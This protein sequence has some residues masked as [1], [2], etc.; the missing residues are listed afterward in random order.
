[1]KTRRD[2][3]KAGFALGA[4]FSLSDLS[5]LYAADAA[6]APAPGGSR[7][8]LVA[9]RDGDRVAMLDKALAELGGIGA[10]VKPGQTVL[11]KPNIG[12]DVPP[13]RGANTHPDLVARLI[14]LCREAGAKSVS[15]F[16]NTCDEWTLSYANSGIEKAAREAGATVVNG[17]DESLYRQ[18]DVPN[19]VKLKSAKVHSL[20]LDSDVFINVPVLKHHSGSL[21]TSAMKNLM[22]IVWDRRAYHRA[23]LHQCIADLLT[24]VKPTLN[25]V[26]AYHPMVRNGPRGKSVEDVIVLK[27]LLASRDIVA[28][29]AA[30]AKLL[31]HQPTDVRHVQLAAA[32]GLGTLDLDQVDIR[33]LR[34]A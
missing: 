21:M 30:A 23:D 31:G 9:V 22:G 24:R 1:M 27:T 29:D 33:R 13:E 7:S 15:V 18:T 5:G 25:I 11:I 17:K 3:I 32:H 14:T 20:A 26:D 12:W 8:I 10:F 2:F 16:D 28:V 4:S 34:L 19:G 6:T